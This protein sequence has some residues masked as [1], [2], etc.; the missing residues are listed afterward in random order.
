MY[1]PSEAVESKYAK[2]KTSHSVILPQ[3]WVFSAHTFPLLHPDSYAT[4]SLFVC[5][6]KV[7][8][9]SH[10]YFASILHTNT[11]LVSHTH[12]S[13]VNLEQFASLLYS[14]NL[15]HTSSRWQKYYS[16]QTNSSEMG[17]NLL[18]VCPRVKWSLQKNH[19]NLLILPRSLTQSLSSIHF[20][21]F[22]PPST[23]RIFITYLSCTE[24]R[25]PLERTNE[26]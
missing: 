16:L 7:I 6:C 15:W 2:L 10:T 19:F 3:R 20:F 17:D 1:V 8:S 24:G 4:L 12:K 21:A 25:R 11:L 23:T 22:T 26:R 5:V 13:T 9:K 18:K 14:L